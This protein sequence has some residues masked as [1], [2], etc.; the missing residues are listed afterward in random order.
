[1]VELGA[2]MAGKNMDY[3]YDEQIKRYLLQLIR[4]FSHFQ[5]KEYTSEGV[6]YNRVPC[7]YA[8]ASRMVSHILR[9]NSENIV[10]NAP[11]ISVGIQSLQLARERAQ[12]PF[13]VDTQQVAE[14][15]WNKEAGSYTSEQGNLYTVQRYM[16]VPYNMTIQ[17]DIF[18]TNTDTKLQILE[19]IFVLF[20]PSIQLQSNDN[21]LDWSNVFEVELT[22]ISWSN[23]SI[24]AGVDESLDISTLTFQVPIWISPPA[25]VQRQKIIQKIIADIHS[26]NNLMSL[27]F[28]SDFHDFF[29]SVPED[30]RVVTAPDLRVH[31]ENATASLVNLSGQPVNWSE[32]IEMNGEL[33]SVSRLEFNITDDI[34]DYSQMVIGTIVGNP[35]DSTSLIFNLDSETL[36]ADT[37]TP[38]NRIVDPRSS[39]PGDTLPSAQLAQRYLITENI[40]EDYAEWGIDAEAND[41]VEYDGNKWVVV[42]DSDQV[43]QQ[44]WITN[45]F[46]GQ[47]FRWTGTEWISSWQGTYN[48][49]YWKLIL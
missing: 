23:R 13:M 22:D 29:A 14:R 36:P 32:I 45:D 6:N 38:L 20:N 10:N 47:Q 33:T 17:V 1:M 2:N 18:T 26:N 21:P 28:N 34:K 49:G 41:I 31:I 5:V 44:A 11:Q 8:D 4:I 24:P 19:Q 15:E 37:L 42:F 30:A 9:N 3:W 48:P 40:T 12:D 7:R 16:P 39:R 46:T 27:G 25:K 35:L 43:S